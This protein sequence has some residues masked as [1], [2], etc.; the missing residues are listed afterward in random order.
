MKNLTFLIL[1]F[2][3]SYTTL[4]QNN[5]SAKVLA[6]LSIDARTRVLAFFDCIEQLGLNELDAGL[7]QELINQITLSFTLNGTVEERSKYRS[8]GVTRKIREYLNLVRYRG[9]RKLVIINYEII[10][11]L[12]ANELVP[13]K[14]SD[15]TVS[16]KGY[17]IVRQFYCRMKEGDKL[18]DTLDNCAYQDVTD[19]KVYVEIRQLD[20][21]LGRS[22]VA[23]IERIVV[24]SVK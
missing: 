15:G 22:W 4:A 7:K 8:Y 1:S 3:I 9:E 11:N 24:L 23:L 21:N 6:D 10:D 2:A 17:I 14:N 13:H 20:S 18:L 12:S 19:K 16:Y 5:L